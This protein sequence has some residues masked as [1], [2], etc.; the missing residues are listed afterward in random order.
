MAGKS[1]TPPLTFDLTDLAVRADRARRF[2]IIQSNFV[3][4]FGAVLVVVGAYFFLY[5][6]AGSI[7]PHSSGPL[8]FIAIG[9]IVVGYGSWIIYRLGPSARR[10]VISR[11]F[12]SLE[13]IPGRKSVRLLWNQPGFRLDIHDFREIRNADPQ[14]KS[15]GYE[16][17]LHPSRGPETAVPMRAVDAII[18]QA[19]RHGLQVGRRSVSV[20][21]KAPMIVVSIQSST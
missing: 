11:D 5:P 18:E 13:D 2:R 15:R 6:P 14:S 19:E 16:F 8:L 7:P 17:V 12:L 3:R 21:A 10:L 20:G 9:A 1:A 4:A